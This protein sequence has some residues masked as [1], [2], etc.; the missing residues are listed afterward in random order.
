MTPGTGDPTAAAGAG[1]R[2]SQDPFHSV[3]T[4]RDVYDAVRETQFEVRSTRDQVA[5]L[6]R[7]YT[8]LASRTDD[9]DRRIG[10]LERTTVTGDALDARTRRIWMILGVVV[11]AAGVLSAVV[12]NLLP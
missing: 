11:S 7:Q 6:H 10:A 9:A 2:T 4:A 8:E 1:S 12:Y 5:N 3:V